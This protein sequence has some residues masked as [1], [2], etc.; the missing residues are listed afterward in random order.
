VSTKPWD[1]GTGPSLLRGMLARWQHRPASGPAA[2][3]WDM[4]G[5]LVNSEPVWTIAERELFA[6]WGVPF[7]PEMKAAMVGTRLDVSVPMMIRFGGASAVTAQ[8]S[9][10]Q[11]QAFLLGRM[12]QLLAVSVPVLPGARELLAE[13]AAAAIP[14]ALIS[15]SY[16]VLVDAVL[17]GLPGHPFAV[18]VAGDEVA[19]GKPDPEPYESAAQRLGVPIGGCVVLE[20]SPTGARSGAVAGARVLYCPSVSGAGEPEPGWRPVA[21]LTEVS[22][23]GLRSWFRG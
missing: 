13:A 12:T 22:L 10:P 6:G 18:S 2:L 15:S 23:A 14:Q 19:R 9:V 17:A 21:S 20:D 5:L 4:D 3:L 16:R 1:P 8:A 11:V 7:T